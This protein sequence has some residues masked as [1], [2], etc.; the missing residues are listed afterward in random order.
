MTMLVISVLRLIRNCVFRTL[1]V[2]GLHQ[3]KDYRT[4][5]GLAVM[6]NT[7]PSLNI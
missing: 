3:N 7:E 4:P 6:N 1:Q 2:Q 5:V